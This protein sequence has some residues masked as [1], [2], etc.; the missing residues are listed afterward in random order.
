MITGIGTDICKI[1]R[2]EAGL[3]R[4]GDKFY[5]RVLTEKEREG[6]W[7]P[8]QF[9]RR[10]AMKEAVAKA[11]GFGIGAN[12]SFH[13]IEIFRDEKG[14]PVCT[15]KGYEDHIVHVSASDDGEFATGMAVIERL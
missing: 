6:R 5:A 3:A 2:I 10:W 14:K 12:L 4:F 13:D 8:R 11:T 1:E 15:V 7:G 9:A